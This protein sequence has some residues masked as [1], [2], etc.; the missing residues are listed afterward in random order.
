MQL[1]NRQR[2]GGSK[3]FPV[4]WHDPCDVGTPGGKLDVVHL[5]SLVRP[6]LTT[7]SAKS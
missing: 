5:K 3:W 6:C 2:R 1:R 4:V 7:R